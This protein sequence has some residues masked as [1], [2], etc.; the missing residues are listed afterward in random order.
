VEA[1]GE[2]P[3]PRYGIANLERRKHKR[4]SVNLPVAY[5]RIDS[6]IP[7]SGQTGNISEG[8]F[9]L[10][11]KEKMEVGQQLRLKLFFSLG[12]GLKSIEGMGEL[13]WIGAPGDEK[14][15]SYACGVKFLRIS[16]EDQTKLEEFLKTIA[17]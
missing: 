2:E 11:L 4:F 1:K 15:G 14:W 3:K 13:V 16:P 6:P 9:M 5:H 10:Y 12:S 7:S 17:P 8:G